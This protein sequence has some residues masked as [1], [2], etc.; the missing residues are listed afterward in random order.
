MA[1]VP[2]R[3][4]LEPALDAARRALR[5]LDDD[6]VPARLRKVAA[7]SARR[8][9]GPFADSLTA[10]LDA[11]PWLRGLALDAWEEADPDDPDGPRAVSALFLARPDGWVARVAERLEGLER[12]AVAARAEEAERRSVDL[13]ERVRALEARLE[14]ERTRARRREADLRDAR[15]DE[16][17]RL[18]DAVADLR[19]RLSAAEAAAAGEAERTARLRSDLAEADA[20]ISVL[21]DRLLRERRAARGT[22]DHAAGG[23]GRFGRGDPVETA[24]M[25]DQLVEAVRPSSGTSV[26]PEEA[27]P[28][29]LPAGTRPDRAEA[30]EW[31][32]GLGRPSTLVVDGYNVAHALDP[33]PGPTVRAR[34]VHALERVRRLAD[35]PVAVVVFWD[36][37]DEW[38][39]RE[40]GGVRI[41][42]VPDADAAVVAEAASVS[43]TVVV[44]SADR[45]VRERAQASG[46][47]GLWSGALLDWMDRG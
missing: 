29:G 16:M 9:P 26:S 40:A 19:R 42:F 6:R 37:A 3:T 46:A 47:V 23:V 45:E 25:L 31:L 15:Q 28:V 4:V 8:L 17:A 22:D 38:G 14:E 39:A 12:A 2:P 30:I 5:E 1:S 7:S 35:G 36:S 34:V 27:T 21:R 44:V 33:D 41:R 24:R 11:D 32:L 13:E 18:S 10:A 43:G 20:R